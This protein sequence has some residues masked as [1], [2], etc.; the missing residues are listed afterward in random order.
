MNLGTGIIGGRRVRLQFNQF[1][2]NAGGSSSISVGGLAFGDEHPTRRVFA[3][4]GAV[5]FRSSGGPKS[6]TIGGVAATQHVQNSPAGGIGS[7]AFA[8]IWSASVPTGTTGTI[9]FNSGDGSNI[10]NVDIG[11]YS[12]Y[13]QRDSA[14]FDTNAYADG[15]SGTGTLSLDIPQGGFVLACCCQSNTLVC[16]SSLSSSP[17]LNSDAHDQTP[18]MQGRWGSSSLMA[19]A[20][21][22][23]LTGSFTNSGGGPFHS[24]GASASFR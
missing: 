22:L 3:V 8:G 20:S 13:G 18:N 1:S 15:S 9:A 4:I 12:S 2:I 11:V 7:A 6:V 23:V 21:P 14:A 17:A 24:A 16:T 19:A 5:M 10:G